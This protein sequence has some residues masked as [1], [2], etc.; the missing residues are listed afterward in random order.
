MEAL[1][2][3]KLADAQRQVQKMLKYETAPFTQNNFD[4]SE[5][6]DEFLALYKRVR[7]EAKSA[8]AGAQT[9]R[10]PPR[11][12]QVGDRNDEVSKSHMKPTVQKQGAAEAVAAASTHGPV[13]PPAVAP[14]PTP[15]PVPT[16]VLGSAPSQVQVAN[17][18]GLGFPAKPVSRGFWM[19]DTFR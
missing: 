13:S 8:P 16:L 11:R 12:A 17:A 5:S 6:K 1:V 2:H 19:R 4:L 14:A 7:R 3:A 15:A 9:A 18:I 10:L